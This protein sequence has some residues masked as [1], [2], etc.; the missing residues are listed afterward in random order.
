MLCLRTST[1]EVFHSKFLLKFAI[2]RPCHSNQA[3]KYSSQLLF[4][5]SDRI[6][7]VMRRLNLETLNLVLEGPD[8]AH[9]IGGFVRGDRAGD[10]GAS[11]S[12]STSE[13]HL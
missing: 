7:V 13:S 10:D 6:F 5:R 9:Q 11:D 1:L 4:L 2:R 12:A 3:S 8:L